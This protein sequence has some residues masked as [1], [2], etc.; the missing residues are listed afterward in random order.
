[1]RCW[2]IAALV[3][4][5]ACSVKQVTF[6]G[7]GVMGDDP[8][9]PERC[10]IVGDEDGNGLAECNDPACR[11]A[12]GCQASGGPACGNEVVEANEACDDGNMAST[13]ACVEGCLEARCGDGFVRAGAEACDDAN[14][15]TSDACISCVEARC[16]D[17]FVRTGVE[18][19][20]DGNTINNDECDN[21]CKPSPSKYEIAYVDEWTVSAFSFTAFAFVI[22][23]N[24]GSQPL[25]IGTLAVTGFSDDSAQIPWTLNVSGGPPN[26][27]LP[28]G[29][30]AG[31][32]TQEVRQLVTEPN[33][34]MALNFA[35]G[36][37]MM[38]NVVLD[39]HAQATLR[40]DGVSVT[41]PMLIH[42]VPVSGTPFIR[43]DHATRITAF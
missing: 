26:I 35:M 18:Q 23:V 37:N 30:A 25:P 12:P 21:E 24:T 4:L 31:V 16:G 3:A 41:L 36:W 1:M 32:A 33:D 29:H 39:L 17:G 10:D 20:D 22:V 40:I 8:V 34:S 2:W 27:T 13:D 19:C 15:D 38:S 7:E 9:E 6:L 42:A 11:G 43:R 14:D 5:A 28:P